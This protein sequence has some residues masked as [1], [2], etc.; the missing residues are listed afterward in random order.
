LR[1]AKE[2]SDKIAACIIDVVSTLDFVLSGLN[3]KMAAIRKWQS[4]DK[5]EKITP[6]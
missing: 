5:I 3:T 4:F 1:W 2:R 6:A